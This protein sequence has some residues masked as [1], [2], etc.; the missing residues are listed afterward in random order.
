[1]KL[2]Y[3]QIF[4]RR[5]DSHIE[6]ILPITHHSDVRES[7]S[8]CLQSVVLLRLGDM[9]VAGNTLGSSRLRR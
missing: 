9:E 5:G 3:S 4:S 8:L 7:V 1:M 6:G 2:F